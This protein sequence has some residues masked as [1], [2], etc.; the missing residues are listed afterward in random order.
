VTLGASRWYL[1][2]RTWEGLAYAKRE[3]VGDGLGD[4]ICM[5]TGVRFRW[6]ECTVSEAQQG[7]ASAF[8]LTE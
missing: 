8:V 1:H 6:L 4:G 3:I 2:G 5:L 7:L